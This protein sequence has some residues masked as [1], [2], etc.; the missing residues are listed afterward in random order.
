MFCVLHLACLGN[1]NVGQEKL[2]QGKTLPCATCS[3]QEGPPILVKQSRLHGSNGIHERR[4][5]VLAE[6]KTR[7]SIG[8]LVR[9]P[10]G[11]QNA[12]GRILDGYARTFKFKEPLAEQKICKL[13][14][15]EETEYLRS[16]MFDSFPGK[17]ISENTKS[18]SS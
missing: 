18:P 14:K 2:S 7:A 4:R 12:G 11:V 10:T 1:E 8:S 9:N 16:L 13:W 6:R 15:V 17:D 5:S 3:S